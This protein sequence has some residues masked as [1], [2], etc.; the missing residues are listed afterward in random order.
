MDSVQNATDTI[1]AALKYDS[2]QCAEYANNEVVALGR[3]AAWTTDGYWHSSNY[4]G[5]NGN[6]SNE[7]AYG[8]NNFVAVWGGL[9][10]YSQSGASW[11]DSASFRAFTT[12]YAT[13]ASMRA[14]CY[15]NGRFVCLGGGSW[16][17]GVVS[18][19]GINW[20]ESMQIRQVCPEFAP[21][22]TSLCWD[23][24]KFIAVGT[25]KSGQ[26]GE[27]YTSPDGFT[28][29]K[30]PQF[31]SMLGGDV[32]ARPQVVRSNG[33][34]KVVCVGQTFVATSDGGVNWTK[35]NMPAKSGIT[36]LGYGDNKFVA[37]GRMGDVFKSY[38]MGATWQPLSCPTT[39]DQSG[40][41]YDGVV[42]YAPPVNLWLIGGGIAGY[43]SAG[44]FSIQ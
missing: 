1:R 18:F 24:S 33:A 13:G 42:T 10:S 43:A 25:F 15:G 6:G 14:L 22:F 20:Q 19:D 5:L 30:Q 3:Y 34:G 35:R 21:S 9:S 44:W 7:L 11:A 2:F 28:W 26:V 32:L 29:T 37:V 16:A 36:G 12:K 8:N 39:L 41:I 27:C 23:G 38:D 17:A 4:D 31:T 40:T